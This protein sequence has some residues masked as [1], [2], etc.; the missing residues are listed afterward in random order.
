MT[1]SV[2]ERQLG[3]SGKVVLV[4]LMI[5]GALLASADPF[6]LV[7]FIVYMPVGAYLVAGRPRNPTL[8]GE[9]RQTT[10]DAVEPSQTAV[11]LRVAKGA[12]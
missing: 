10:V 4:G 7:S 6:G 3:R 1:S 5:V 11:W 9:L 2:G 8:T 12:R